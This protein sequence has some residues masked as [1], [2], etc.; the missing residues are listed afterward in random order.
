LL[1]EPARDSLPALFQSLTEPSPLLLSYW[2]IVVLWIVFVH[3]SFE[4]KPEVF[5]GVEV[6]RLGWPFDAN[7]LVFQMESFHRI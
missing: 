5:N 6:G 7:D 4:S 2:I 3:A 1:D